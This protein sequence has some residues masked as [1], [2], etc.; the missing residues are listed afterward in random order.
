MS[1]VYYGGGGFVAHPA[2][3]GSN[4]VYNGRFNMGTEN[5]FGAGIVGVD[6]GG[7]Y[8]PMCLKTQYASG[9][10]LKSRQM[11][12]IDSEAL[13]HYKADIWGG[14]GATPLTYLLLEPCDV[15]GL[16]ITHIMGA[17]TS[18]VSGTATTLAAPL[19]VGDTTVSLTSSANWSTASIYR[20]IVLFPYTN[21]LGVTYDNYT[22]S[23]Y[24]KNDQFTINGNLLTLASPWTVPNGNA[25]DGIWPAGTPVQQAIDGASYMYPLLKNLN[26]QN[27]WTRFSAYVGGTDSPFWY[28]TSY[29]KPGFLL[30]Y[31]PSTPNPIYI[32]D[33]VFRQEDLKSRA[34]LSTPVVAMT[35]ST[36][37]YT[38]F[39]GLTS[40]GDTSSFISHSGTTTT[41]LKT[42]L[43]LFSFRQA[44]YRTGGEDTFE[45][46]CSGV[47]YLTKGQ[48]L[49]CVLWISDVTNPAVRYF[50]YFRKSGTSVYPV[51]TGYGA[52]PA[53]SNTAAGSLYL[54]PL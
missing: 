7:A 15:D 49:D 34:Y 11:I 30:N 10:D 45:I 4:L 33:V 46:H 13:Y 22:Y 32:S 20:S 16:R 24:A 25:S 47:E 36:N 37:M 44:M 39:T 35:A 23:R 8:S 42:G 14:T 54:T 27:S 31:S 43:Y 21:S 50:G 28:G 26:G 1:K 18:R 12:P 2:N 38:N 19:K 5:W 48:T 53:A 17:P 9:F 52:L 29:V 51:A 40:Q 6:Y 41:I 3:T